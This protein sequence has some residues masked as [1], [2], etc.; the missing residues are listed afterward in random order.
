MSYENV[1]G[2]VGGNVGGN[3][4]VRVSPI[5]PEI[6]PGNEGQIQ[7]K[8]DQLLDQVKKASGVG[9]VLIERIGCV[10]APSAPEK[11]S[12]DRPP[13]ESLVEQRIQEIEDLVQIHTYQLADALERL[14]L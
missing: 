12:G 2:N 5:T 6:N 10:S 7:K 13:G 4:S 8:M 9:A 14:R 1:D 3:V 11:T